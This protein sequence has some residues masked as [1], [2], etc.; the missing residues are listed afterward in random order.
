MFKVLSGQKR[1]IIS[2]ATI[3][4]SVA[5]HILLLGGAVY[6][7]AADRA[8][9]PDE[10]LTGVIEFPPPELEPKQPEV[11]EPTPPAPAQPDEPAPDPVPG[12]TLQLETPTET[13]ENII[14]EP[15]GAVPVDPKEFSGQ[16]PVGN[17]IGEPTGEPVKVVPPAPP[18]EPAEEWVIDDRSV[19]QRPELDRGGLTR[20]MERYYPSVLRDSR[21]AGRVVIEMIVDTDGRVRDGSVRVIETSHPAFG[22][23]ALRAAERFRFRPGKM[24]GTP[25]P[26]RVTLPIQWTVPR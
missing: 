19:E 11:V 8:R 24:A 14:P 25:V 21:V 10:R 23:A 16:G 6:A 13:P 26:V 17:V 18:V 2:P 5:A 9:G 20:A 3:A 1:R 4:A 22:E 7:A 15:V 12:E